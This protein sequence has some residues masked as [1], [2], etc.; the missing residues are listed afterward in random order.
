V[1]SATSA[2]TVVGSTPFAVRGPGVVTSQPRD[3]AFGIRTSTPIVVT[4]DQPV[5]AATVTVQSASGT[6]SGSLQLS[7][8][9]FA[10]CLGFTGG[11]T[12]NA[13]ALVATAQPTAVLT[14]AT[15]YKIRVTSAVTNQAGGAG[16]PFTQAAGF[17]TAAAGTC[18][19]GLV[20]SQVYGAG[21]NGG[22]NVATFLND[23]IELHNGGSTPV[24]LD[25]FAVQYASTAGTSWQVTALP[26]V[27]VPPGGYFL[28]AEAAGAGPA[29]A[30]PT[31]DLTATTPIILM[32]AAN[33]KVALTAS[34]VPLSGGCPLGLTNDFVG[35][36]TASCSEGAGAVGPL[37][38]VTA[39]IRGGGG[40]T[41][42]GNN[43]TDFAVA[44]PTPRNAA[45]APAVCT[46]TGGL[47]DSDAQAMSFLS[48]N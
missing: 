28:V 12:V 22:A 27:V 8:D 25:G 19:S 45:T 29:P 24:N 20:I 40:C 38:N 3:T 42:A 4:F 34:T 23:F 48:D 2:D 47:A 35:Y 32:A 10:S 36:G 7:T 44:L 21:G 6:C 13:A 41:D 31:P 30:L 1:I 15:T 14:A 33:G 43:A 17:A 18:A 9:D 11:A 26:A 46:C 37:G 39:G 16:E 5:A